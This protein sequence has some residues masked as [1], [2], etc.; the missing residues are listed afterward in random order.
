MGK[1]VKVII[2]TLCFRGIYILKLL[3]CG[4]ILLLSEKIFIQNSQEIVSRLVKLNMT[5]DKLSCM[6]FSS[7]FNLSW[8]VMDWVKISSIAF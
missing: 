2:R 7:F 8:K 5:F 1:F 4:N 6:C 3:K